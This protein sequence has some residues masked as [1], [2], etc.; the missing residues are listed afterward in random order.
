MI[1]ESFP[2]P[3]P[4]CSSAFDFLL[5]LSTNQSAGSMSFVV[6]WRFLVGL[7]FGLHY[8]YV[9]ESSFYSVRPV[10]FGSDCRFA[11]G[12]LFL[13]FVDA[14]PIRFVLLILFCF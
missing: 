9:C 8:C 7:S 3:P 5:F 14:Y 11:V 10:F 12:L 2:H 6:T 1:A 13:F 4:C